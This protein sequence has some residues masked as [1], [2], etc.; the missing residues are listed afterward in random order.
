ME[1]EKKDN[2]N[3]EQPLFANDVTIPLK[4]EPEQDV[5][6]NYVNDLRDEEIEGYTKAVRR[7]R[8]ALYVAGVLIFI[9][10][11]IGMAQLPAGLRPLA[12]GIALVEAGIFIV[13]ALWTKKKPY[14]AV[15]TGLIAFIGI[16]LLGA[17]VKAIEEG[18]EGFAIGLFSG[19]LIKIIILVNLISPLRDAKALQNAMKERERENR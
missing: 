17:I 13:L 18:S 9:G 5:I 16:I 11:M 4:T 19:L 12:I 10:E 2:P 14:T 1:P 7:A 6:A 8:N 3:P 15:V